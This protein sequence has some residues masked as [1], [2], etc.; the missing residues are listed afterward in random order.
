M[1]PRPLTAS[2]SFRRSRCGVRGHKGRAVG[3]WKSI[4]RVHVHLQGHA[5]GFEL[6]PSDRRNSLA[7]LDFIIML[8]LTRAVIASAVIVGTVL[9]S[10]GTSFGLSV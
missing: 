3:S 5:G 1:T 6:G 10:L 4:W 2:R 8:L 7:L 9:L